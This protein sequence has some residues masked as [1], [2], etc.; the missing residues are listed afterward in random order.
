MS[1]RSL[2]IFEVSKNFIELVGKFAKNSGEKETDFC[3]REFGIFPDYEY[4]CMGVT[5]LQIHIEHI[6]LRD[7]D[8]VELRCTHGPG[9]RWKRLC[10]ITINSKKY[11]YSVPTS[12]DG[13][14]LVPLEEFLKTFESLTVCFYHDDYVSSATRSNEPPFTFVG[15]RI[16]VEKPGD[17]YLRLS[18]LS[19]Y[20]MHPE[21]NL[22]KI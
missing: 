9:Y 17:Y 22:T 18:Q 2:S 21:S 5:T 15:Y 13:N 16:K 7:V 14:L 20:M 3:I 1:A 10:F 12:E 6:G 11:P 8:F 4:S 19:H